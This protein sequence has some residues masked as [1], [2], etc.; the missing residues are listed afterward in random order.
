MR[1]EATWRTKHRA[2]PAS[3]ARR[4]LVGLRPFLLLAVLLVLGAV[5]DPALVEPVGLLSTAPE[6]V[7]A[8]FTP[9]G[10]GRGRACVIDGDTFKLGERKVRIIGID[11]P[12]LNGQCP[13]ERRLA[14]QAAARLRQLLNQGPFTMTGHIGELQDRYRR[15]LRTL[16]RERPGG[17]LQNIAADMRNSGLARRYVGAKSNW[18]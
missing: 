17:T 3:A 2:R 4:R 12:E 7:S 10:P 9:C 1:R 14:A 18:C 11:T 8:M 5:L 6:Q 15:D 16:T 13:E